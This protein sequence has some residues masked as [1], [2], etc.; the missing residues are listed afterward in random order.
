MNSTEQHG[1]DAGDPEGESFLLPDSG[2]NSPLEELRLI[3]EKRVRTAQNL[4]EEEK[5]RLYRTAHDLARKRLAA[6]LGE[7][8]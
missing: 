8:A 1:P 6:A 3:Y 7:E 5:A 2:L 4:G